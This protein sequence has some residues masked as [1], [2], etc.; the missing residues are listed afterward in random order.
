MCSTIARDSRG[1]LVL[2]LILTAFVA[3]ADAGAATEQGIVAPSDRPCAGDCNV[4]G[5]VTIDEL[6]SGIAIALGAVGEPACAAAFC[7]A[8]CG[9]GPARVRLDVSCLVRAVTNALDGCAADACRDDADCDDGN[10]C[11]ID[12]CLADGCINECACV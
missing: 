9:P 5:R 4:D 3:P 6:M 8:D 1:L 12:Q 10:G 2:C 7:R 11:T